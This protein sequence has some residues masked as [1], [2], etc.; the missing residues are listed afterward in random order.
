MPLVRWVEGIYTC[1]EN[2]LV[3]APTDRLTELSFQ[4]KSYKLCVF[5]SL[6]KVTD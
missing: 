2:K 3:H 5:V 6:Q 1:C 4:L